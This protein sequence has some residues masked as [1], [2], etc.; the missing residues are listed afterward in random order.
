[1]NTSRGASSQQWERTARH[2]KLP[3]GDLSYFEL[4][5]GDE[6]CIH[7]DANPDAYIIGEGVEVGI[8]Q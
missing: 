8:Q 1:M 2:P 3:G 5:G 7:D 6:L 4:T